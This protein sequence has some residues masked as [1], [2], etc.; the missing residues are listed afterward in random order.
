MIK[1]DKVFWVLTITTFLALL[2][3]ILVQDGMF[4]DGI[5]YSAI[6]NNLS[7][8]IGGFWSPHYTKTLAPHFHGHPPLVFGIQSLLFNLLGH[9][10]YT[11]RIYTFLSSIFTAFGIVSCWRLF[12]IDSSLKQF[13]WLPVLLW[14]TIPLNFWAYQNN[15]LENTLGVFTIFSIYFISK[16]LIENKI[17]WLVIG[18]LLIVLAF[19]SK[20]F[21]GLFPLAAPLLY[22]LVF[23]PKPFH[24]PIVYSMVIMLSTL[25]LFYAT[26]TLFP[27][28]KENI[29]SYLHIQVIP[30]LSNELEI[31]EKHHLSIIIK[32]ILELTI[33]IFF[34][35][36]VSIIKWRN[37]KHFKFYYMRHCIYFLLIGISAS[38]PLIITLKQRSFYLVPSVPF[39]ILSIGFLITPFVKEKLDKLSKSTL[40][41][42]MSASLVSFL[43]VIAIS[44]YN[45]G[46]FSR[47][48]EK[49]KD[50][51]TISSFIPKGTVIS[52]TKNIWIDW[53]LQ[54]S[55]SRIGYIS[56]DCDNTHK[57]FLIDKTN[58]DSVTIGKYEN[59]NLKLSKYMMLIRKN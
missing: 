4:L 30:S 27:E 58:I 43:L 26:L 42:I 37:N 9:G 11:E 51:Y 57:Y 20:G 22:L 2:L 31:T 15:L 48:E 39:Y 56:L 12:V 25:A 10:I 33:P 23:K 1:I 32:L 3:P 45:F 28:S 44:I 21:V 8:G 41:R 13:S 16:S 52:T 50:V 59:M 24:Y 6:S 7:N 54:A 14:I 36:I 38:I 19:F 17:T 34:L 29:L 49:L 53:S 40:K 35:L 47:D 46:K 5:T 18:S 55:M